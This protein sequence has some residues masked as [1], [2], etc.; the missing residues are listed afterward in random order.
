M[1]IRAFPPHYQSVHF[2][3]YISSFSVI[4]YDVKHFPLQRK[5]IFFTFE[6]DLLYMMKNI[7][8]REKKF[9]ST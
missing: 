2:N 4:S 9:L 7:S 1:Q 5:M 6:N 3:I 8:L